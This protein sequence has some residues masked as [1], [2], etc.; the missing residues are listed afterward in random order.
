MSRG[1]HLRPRQMDGLPVVEVTVYSSRNKN[2]NV[3]GCV[4]QWNRPIQMSRFVCSRASN[5]H[6][7]H[8]VFHGMIAHWSGLGRAQGTKN[9]ILSPQRPTKG[10]ETQ[11]RCISRY[12]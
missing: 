2:S 11:I 3:K 4:A 6:H 10:L 5:A 8:D 12:V 7:D 1:I 9:E